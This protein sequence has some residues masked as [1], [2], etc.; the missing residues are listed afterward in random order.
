MG[1]LL[2]S[3]RVASLFFLLRHAT[4][5]YGGRNILILLFWTVGGGF[6]ACSVWASRWLRSEGSNPRQCCSHLRHKE[7]RSAEHVGC[8]H[9][10]TKAP[11]PIRTPKLSVLGRERS[12][13]RRVGGKCWCWMPFFFLSHATTGYG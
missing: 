12:E 4:T 6:M 8:D 5:G 1:D 10:S 7:K 9:T 13:E 3:P 2:G 11:D